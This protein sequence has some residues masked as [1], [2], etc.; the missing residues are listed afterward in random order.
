MAFK[1]TFSAACVA[2]FALSAPIHAD[3]HAS[4]DTVVATVNGV[5]ITLA[6]MIVLKQRLP[7]QYQ[8]LPADVLFNGILDQLVQQ[9]VLGQ[10]GG[11]LS[12]GSQATL[13]NEERALRASELIQ[14]ITDVAIT[15]DALQ[16][17]YDETYA[18]IEP[19]TEYNASHILVETEDEALA[20]IEEIEGGAEFAL[21]AQEKSTGPSGP[22]GG[23]LG[24]FGTGAMV[25]PFEEAVVAMEAGTV[26]APVQ[27]QF[28]WHVIRLNETRLT[29]GP[30]LDAVRGDLVAQLRQVAVEA[31]VAELTE[32][33]DITRVTVEDVDP[34]LLDD[35]SLLG[36]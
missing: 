33:A 20:I 6:H 5:D 21:V 31:R 4:A 9:T 23:Q 8:S 24:W 11:E 13:E 12:P 10:S 16:A 7:A 19:E 2:L 14:G 32:G 30:P 27:T 36:N 15:E 17:A 18:G 25:A 28:G 3:G 34:A 26:S 1:Q 22:N 35:L 29:E